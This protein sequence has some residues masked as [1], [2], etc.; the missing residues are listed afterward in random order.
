MKS[1]VRTRQMRESDRNFVT[2]SWI[3]TYRHCAPVRHVCND[4]YYVGQYKRIIKILSVCDVVIA[5]SDE[6][7]DLM[8]GFCAYSKNNTVH[9]IYVKSAYRRY[10][11]ARIMLHDAGIEK[12]KRV[13]VTH[14][15]S[16]VCYS[17]G[18]DCDYNPYF[19]DDI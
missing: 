15:D 19:A 8:F 7:D 9:Y 1:V 5:V 18:Y 17:I 10:G 16:K 14:W 3:E 6:D 11:I 4:V 2:K 13:T 12:N